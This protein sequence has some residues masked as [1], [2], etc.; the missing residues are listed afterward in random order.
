M[1]PLHAIPTEVIRKGFRPYRGFITS[2]LVNLPQD[3]Q[4]LRHH[5]G[6]PLSALSA[7]TTM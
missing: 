6:R 4:A 1:L 7:A 2:L 3:D 5:L